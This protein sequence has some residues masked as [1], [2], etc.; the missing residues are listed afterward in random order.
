MSNAQDPAVR[1]SLFGRMWN[2]IVAGLGTPPEQPLLAPGTG[3][4]HSEIR[5]SPKPQPLSQAEPRKTRTKRPAPLKTVVVHLKTDQVLKGALVSIDQDMMTL[6]HASLAVSGPSGSI[7]WQRMD[8]EVVM[9]LENVDFWQAGLDA[10][11]LDRTI[12]IPAD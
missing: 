7:N 11:I 8:G 3:W 2:G 4:G 12:D 6:K 9:A 10:T 1:A 5:E